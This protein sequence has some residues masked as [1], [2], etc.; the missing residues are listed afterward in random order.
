MSPV[1]FNRLTPEIMQFFAGS[2]GRA[3]WKGHLKVLRQ[4]LIKPI[5]KGDV[6]VSKEI[7]NEAFKL[8]ALLSQRLP[9]LPNERPSPTVSCI[10]LINGEEGELDGIRVGQPNAA[11]T[12]IAAGLKR[13]ISCLSIGYEDG[14]TFIIAAEGMKILDKIASTIAIQ[15]INEYFNMTLDKAIF[16]YAAAFGSA[17]EAITLKSNS[18]ETKV[19]SALI[20]GNE[21]IIATAGEL[22]AALYRN[23]SLDVFGKTTFEKPLSYQLK[24][25]TN[26]DSHPVQRRLEDGDILVLGSTALRTLSSK[27][28]QNILINKAFDSALEIERALAEAALRKIKEGSIEMNLTIAVYKHAKVEEIPEEERSLEDQGTV[29]EG[30]ESKPGI[31]EESDEELV[32]NAT[33]YL[34]LSKEEQSKLAKALDENAEYKA[35]I[36]KAARIIASYN[37]EN[38]AL[39]R[40]NKYLHSELHALR[41]K[42]AKAEQAPQEPELE[43]LRGLLTG[44]T[45]EKEKILDAIQSGAYDTSGKELIIIQLIAAGCQAEPSL[46]SK[47]RDTIDFINIEPEEEA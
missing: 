47:A 27:E 23:G 17:I 35:A 34:G 26:V 30:A 11:G 31:P 3:K 18:M 43:P 36:Q 29:I 12:S 8:Q 4:N 33:K 9:E 14:A 15:E 16:S 10:K 5:I 2:I 42:L 44:T 46:I 41:T 20:H 25:S 1:R 45:Q 22:A 28:V 37:S 6:A 13:N 24:K 38:E 39:E 19:A 32:T 21:T 7:K 40:E